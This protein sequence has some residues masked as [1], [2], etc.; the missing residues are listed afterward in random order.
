M[1]RL[2]RFRKIRAALLILVGSQPATFPPNQPATFCVSEKLHTKNLHHIHRQGVVNIYQAVQNICHELCI[3]H[4]L[5]DLHELSGIFFICQPPGSLHAR[6]LR[7][8][9]TK[10]ASRSANDANGANKQED[11]CCVHELRG[12][13]RHEKWHQQTEHC[14][15]VVQGHIKPKQCCSSPWKEPKD[16]K[17]VEH[18]TRSEPNRLCHGSLKSHCRKRQEECLHH[19]SGYPPVR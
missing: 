5:E 10:D 19:R 8:K 1:Y 17:K 7:S 11:V 2:V 12:I 15:Q 16:R 18:Q 9:D 14:K 4:D 6:G 13:C 3:V